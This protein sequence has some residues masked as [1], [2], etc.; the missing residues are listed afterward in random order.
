LGQPQ[1]VNPDADSTSASARLGEADDIADPVAAQIVAAMRERGAQVLNIHRVALLSPRLA[2]AIGQY[3]LSLRA[4]TVLPKRLG[5]F[6][7]LR[8]AHV[9]EARY[10]WSQHLPM[11]RGAGVT[12]AQIRDLPSWRSSAEFGELERVVLE[13]VDQAIPSGA[14]GNDAFER[15]RAFLSARELV[16][17]TSLIGAYVSAA[18]FT[19]A[20]RVA[21]DA[22]RPTVATTSTMTRG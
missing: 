9:L 6:A 14:V 17:L 1:I 4:D 5:E 18:I 12:E 13:Y 2:Q 10:V 16:E 15:A 3:M 7:V 20:L 19:G 21:P 11:A 22:E 8:T